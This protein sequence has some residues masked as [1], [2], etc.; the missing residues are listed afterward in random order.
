MTDHQQQNEPAN[1]DAT[2]IAVAA[3]A[4]LPLDQRKVL[5]VAVASDLT[6]NDIASQGGFPP[7]QI[8]GWMREG[9]HIIADAL[10][11]HGEQGQAS[12]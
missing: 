1:A 9:L 8:L 5:T 7:S 10:D 3:V 12:G 6:Y 4:S 11:H 2:A